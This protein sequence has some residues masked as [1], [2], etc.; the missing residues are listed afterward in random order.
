MAD[1]RSALDAVLKPADEWRWTALDL[2]AG[3]GGLALGFEAAGFKT[4]GF[5]MAHDGVETYNKNLSG[6]CYEAFLTADFEF[7]NADLIIGGPPCQPFS[8]GGRQQGLKDSRDGFPAF[9]SSVRRV[10]PSL[11]LFENVRGMMYRNRAYF[12]EILRDL[13][14]L[15]YAVEVKLLNAV[16][17][18]VPQNRERLIVVGHR[19]PF[20]FPEELKHR[21]TAGQGLGSL[22]R[23][24]PPDSKW[25]TPA[26]DEYIKRY[27]DKSKCVTP[28]DLHLD[29]PARTLTCRNLAGAT[30]DMQRIKV[31]D[32]RRRRLTTREAARLQSFPDWYQ[33]AGNEASVYKQIGNAVAPLFALSLAQ[34]I[35]AHL[36]G[37]LTATDEDRLF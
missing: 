35:A 8:V 18:G 14:A 5:E 11:F 1:Y 25:L 15:G 9:I 34:S 36:D 20:V 33:F 17:F 28:R 6:E 4:I 26:M 13:R 10:Q 2:F 21:V 31:A 27:E 29:R 37:G 7:P 30:S 22:V 23:E 24:A 12:D 32:G 19:T 3:C 16:H